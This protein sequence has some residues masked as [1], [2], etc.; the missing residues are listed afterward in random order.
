MGAI[1]DIFR[2]Y[3]PQYMETFK[4]SMPANHLKVI[5]AIVNCRTQILGATLYQCETCAKPH[6]FL[7]S[8]GIRHCPS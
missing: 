8:C 2:S 6:L 5:H 7:R 1:N 3:G 4:D